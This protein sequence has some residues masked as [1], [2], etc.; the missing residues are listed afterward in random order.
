M[1]LAAEFLVAHGI[2][3][4]EH[5]DDDGDQQ[6]DAVGAQE[7]AHGD[8]AAGQRR[9][10]LADAVEHADDLGHH[11]SHHR[12][13]HADRHHGQGDGVDQGDHQ[14]AAQLLAAVGVIGQALQHL[15]QPAGLFA[16]FH[17]GAEQHREGAGE[18]RHGAGQAV[19]LNHARAHAQRDALHALALALLRHRGQGLVQRQA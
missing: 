11:E 15:V 18:L 4:Q 1:H 13:D 2:D 3:E 12:H 8:Q 6:V 7:V 10:R 16:G 9:Q 14:L 19:A 17:G 5:R